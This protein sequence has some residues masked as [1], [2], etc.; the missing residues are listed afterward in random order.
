MAHSIKGDV[1]V[2]CDA[3]NLLFFELNPV[4]NNLAVVGGIPVVGET[5]E[6]TRDKIKFNSYIALPQKEPVTHIYELAGPTQA[7][8]ILTGQIDGSIIVINYATQAKILDLRV[9]P[10]N[11]LFYM[12]PYADFHVEHNP[13]LL[14]NE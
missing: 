10:P 11:V 6:I 3:G 7:G 5:K 9:T 13:V 2:G 8:L 4:Q 1:V 12:R 14:I